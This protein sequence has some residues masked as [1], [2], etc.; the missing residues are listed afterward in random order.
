M[1]PAARAYASRASVR[2]ALCAIVAAYLG[3]ATLWAIRVPPFAPPDE[4]AHTDYMY[5]FFDAG[6]FYRV[7]SRLSA[8]DVLP[9]TRY[10]ERISRLPALA[11]Q[12]A[13]AR[14]RRLRDA[15]VLRRGPGA[16]RR[17]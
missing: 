9:Q 10:L 8:N 3:F 12:R 5:A 11:L 13:R 16:G 2:F 17:P 4:M 15:Y 1:T 6:R 14:T 7:D